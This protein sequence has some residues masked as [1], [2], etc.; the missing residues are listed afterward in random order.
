MIYKF[1]IALLVLFFISMSEDMNIE[2]SYVDSS[3]T[4]S[5]STQIDLYQTLA[6]KHNIFGTMKLLTGIYFIGATIFSINNN[7]K[8]IDET[9]IYLISHIGFISLAAVDFKISSK[10]ELC[11]EVLN[12]RLICDLQ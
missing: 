1:I 6:H 7:K 10:Y 5:Y 3:I 2:L 12:K 8:W 4:N 11:A 9:S